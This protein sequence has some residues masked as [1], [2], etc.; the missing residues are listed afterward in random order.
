MSKILLIEDDA[1]MVN[2]LTTL[3]EIEGYEV[4]AF[5]GKNDV[6]NTVRSVKPD[7]IILDVNLKNFG[8]E[9]KTGFDLLRD[10]KTDDST[11]ESGII[12]SSGMNYQRESKEL[13]A[14]GFIMKPYMPDDLLD[15]IKTIT[16]NQ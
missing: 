7:V 3:L 16:N 2:L 15:T 4:I 9:G 12:I 1:V 14:D 10:F 5:E 8:I 11:K 13:G 6:Y